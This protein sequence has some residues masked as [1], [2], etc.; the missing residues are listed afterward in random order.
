VRGYLLRAVVAVL[1][2][3]PLGA[4]R[5][6]GRF[7]GR[8][9]HALARRE[10]ARAQAHLRLAFPDAEAAFIEDTVRA[11]FQNLGEHALE[12]CVVHRLDRD[13]ERHVTLESSGRACL[14][15]ALAEGKGCLILT[16]HIGSWELAARAL[17]AFGYEVVAVARR[18]NDA[19]LAFLVDRLRESGGVVALQRGAPGTIRRMLGQFKKGGALFMLVDQDTDVPSVFAPFFGRLAKTPRAPADLALRTGAPILMGF[20]HRDGPGGTHRIRM[21]RLEA[22]SPTGN[23][24]ADVLATTAAINAHLEAEIRAH[25]ADWVWFHERWRSQPDAAPA[26]AMAQKA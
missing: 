3:L 25:P 1:G 9:G 15:A 7:L 20:I 13:M 22:P 6:L 8:M 21:E 11:A 14:D 12:L 2:L 24:E 23:R 18:F 26:P 19:G 16:G 10:R 17:V 4:A 5:R